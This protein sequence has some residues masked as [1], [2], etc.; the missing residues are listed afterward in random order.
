MNKSSLA[1]AV[2]LNPGTFSQI[3]K[4]EREL[5]ADEFNDICNEMGT[6]CDKLIEYGKE[7]EAQEE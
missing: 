2:N 3:L 6:S 7:L 5:K 4:G 1:R